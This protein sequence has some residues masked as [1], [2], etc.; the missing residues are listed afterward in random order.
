MLPGIPVLLPRLLMFGAE[1][2]LDPH[3][4]VTIAAA[5]ISVRT[6]EEWLLVFSSFLPVPPTGKI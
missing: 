1:Y 5:E 4:P 2:N 6:W 3:L